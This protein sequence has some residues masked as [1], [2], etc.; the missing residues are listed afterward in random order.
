AAA[1]APLAGDPYLAGSEPD[2]VIP[3]RI[4]YEAS[5]EV[6][7]AAA[8]TARSRNATGSHPL[9]SAV[10]S[11]LAEA[12]RLLAGHPGVGGR[13]TPHRPAN[14]TRLLARG[15]TAGA[16]QEADAILAAADQD[17]D[18]RDAALL[19]AEGLPGAG[20]GKSFLI[21]RAVRNLQRRRVEHREEW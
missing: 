14:A 5:V 10:E 18:A 16:V 11:E 6:A 4:R 7:S 3:P 21:A 2:L 1:D 13:S 20:T 9:W 12:D 19:L 8:D 17:V 15:D